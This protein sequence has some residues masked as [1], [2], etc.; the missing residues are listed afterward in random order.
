MLFT[1]DKL[2]LAGEQFALEEAAGLALQ[3]A[4]GLTQLHSHNIV[5][6]SLKPS[7]VLLDNLRNDVVLSD[8]AISTVLYRL[9]EVPSAKL[10]A[11]YT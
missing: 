3:I 7:N 9:P 2:C 11:L 8:F 6:G 10:L 5:H 1:S 4:E